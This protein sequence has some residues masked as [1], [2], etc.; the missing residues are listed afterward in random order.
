MNIIIEGK[1]KNVLTDEEK[2]VLIK[3]LKGYR[4]TPEESK[5]RERLRNFIY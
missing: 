4:L 5:I 2:A 1:V 3:I